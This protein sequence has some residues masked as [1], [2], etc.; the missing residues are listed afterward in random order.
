MIG[1]FFG[2]DGVRDGHYP[3]EWIASVVPA[4]TPSAGG[5]KIGKSI[6]ISAG[7]NR[8]RSE[9]RQQMGSTS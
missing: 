2:E 8:H 7:R 3:E 4:L 9:E 6:M 5:G 1:A